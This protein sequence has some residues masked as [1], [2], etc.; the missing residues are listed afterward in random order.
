MKKMMIVSAVVVGLLLNI[1]CFG[2]HAQ[3]LPGG[4]S[5][6]ISKSQI[7]DIIGRSPLLEKSGISQGKQLTYLVFSWGQGTV[8]ECYIINGRLAY[9]K[10]KNY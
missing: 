5:I 4:L 7:V 10:F 3:S 9:A 6:G 2:S 8:L 1:F